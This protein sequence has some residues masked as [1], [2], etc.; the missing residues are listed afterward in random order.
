MDERSQSGPWDLQ[1]PERSVADDVEPSPTV[2]QNMMQLDVGNDR[3]GDER[4][5]AGPCHV[6][7]AV[8]CPEGDSGA[9]PPLVWGC[10]RDPWVPDRTS[11]RRDLRFLQEVSSQLSSYITYSFL[12]R[13]LSSL[14]SESPVRMSLRTSS[15]D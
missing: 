15:G 1:L 11:R 4:Q 12:R 9:P 2:D 5:Y 6:L 13:S 10:L 8:G 7:G 14:E 3:G